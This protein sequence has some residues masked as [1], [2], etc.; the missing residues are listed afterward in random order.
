MPLPKNL[1]QCFRIDGSVALHVAVL[2]QGQ[3]RKKLK[4]F[5]HRQVNYAAGYAAKLKKR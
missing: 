1:A 3:S 5:L 4:R 2:R